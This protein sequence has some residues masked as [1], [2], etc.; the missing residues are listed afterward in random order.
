MKK[1]LTTIAALCLFA[2]AVHAQSYGVVTPSLGTFTSIAATATSN[3]IVVI[4]CKKAQN[5]AIEVN[6]KLSGAGTGNQTLTL[7]KSL[8]GSTTTADTVAAGKNTWIIAGNGTTT[9]TGTTNIATG[10]AG[11]LILQSWANGDASRYAT[12]ISVRYSVKRDAP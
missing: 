6:F 3:N 1:I 2:I 4:D 11:F 5:V 7:T 12:N 10:G 8:D 9:V